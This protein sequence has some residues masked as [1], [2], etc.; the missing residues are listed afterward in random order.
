MSTERVVELSIDVLVQPLNIKNY[1]DGVARAKIPEETEDFFWHEG[2]LD[3]VKM[4]E[5]EVRVNPHWA[6]E[7]IAG[8]IS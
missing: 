8:S 4:C 1:T 6:D 5:W 2:V 3:S 7:V